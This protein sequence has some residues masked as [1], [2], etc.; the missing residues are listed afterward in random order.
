[1]FMTSII[2]PSYIVKWCDSI[3]R[4]KFWKEPKYANKTLVLKSV[5][6]SC[7]VGYGATNENKYKYWHQFVSKYKFSEKK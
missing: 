4:W 3:E 5:E 6:L 1:M 2:I 7:F